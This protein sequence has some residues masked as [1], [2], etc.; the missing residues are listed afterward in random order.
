M[1]ADI[2]TN[3]GPAAGSSLNHEPQN[4][5][6]LSTYNFA[7]GGLNDDLRTDRDTYLQQRQHTPRNQHYSAHYHEM[8]QALQILRQVRGTYRY[9]V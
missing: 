9:L 6:P 2:S 4:S 7:S 1:S 8:A 3:P 5:L